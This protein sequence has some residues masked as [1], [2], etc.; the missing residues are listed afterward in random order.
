MGQ[1]GPGRGA[2]AARTLRVS[3]ARIV[4]YE[5]LMRSVSSMSGTLPKG[6]IHYLTDTAGLGMPCCDMLISTQK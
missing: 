5:V 6:L 4:S 1:V 2:R 3:V